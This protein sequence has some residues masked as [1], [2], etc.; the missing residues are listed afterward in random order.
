MGDWVMWLTQNCRNGSAR[1]LISKGEAM[2]AEFV[3]D[4]SDGPD[5]L[6]RDI[7]LVFGSL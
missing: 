1:R 3:S 5:I 2:G 4:Y 6:L 7:W